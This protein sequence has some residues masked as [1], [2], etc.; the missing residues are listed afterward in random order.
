MDCKATGP[1][2]NQIVPIKSQVTVI[3]MLLPPASEGWRKVMFSHASVCVCVGG[4][5]KPTFQ[6][7]GGGV[8]NL[9]RYPLTPIQGRYP[10]PIQGRYP[11]PP[12]ED[13]AA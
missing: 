2:T 11:L 4:E 12:P 9:G 1:I 3:L 10:L 6:P 7:T 13:R 8:P 5:G